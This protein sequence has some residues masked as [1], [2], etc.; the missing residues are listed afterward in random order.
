MYNKGTPPKKKKK[1]T[2]GNYLSP[3]RKHA[4]D[5]G[6]E[7]IGPRVVRKLILVGLR[8]LLKGPWDLVT[9]VI[10]KVTILIVTYEPQLRYL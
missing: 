3:Y 8:A 2:I 10:N 6:R 7:A 1:K 9:G 4:A 5:H